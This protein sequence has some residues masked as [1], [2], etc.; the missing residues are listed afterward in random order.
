MYLPCTG[1]EEV[2]PT[3]WAE[4][5]TS[6]RRWWACSSWSTGIKESSSAHS[7]LTTEEGGYVLRAPAW[8]LL[9]PQTVEARGTKTQADTQVPADTQERSELLGAAQTEEPG[10]A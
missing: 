4:E 8:E 10:G 5:A 1:K 2:N 6:P 7:E 3:L 9:K